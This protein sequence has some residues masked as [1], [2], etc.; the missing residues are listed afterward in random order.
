MKW[1]TS[2]IGC[3][4]CHSSLW[5]T[6]QHTCTSR[7]VRRGGGG[8]GGWGVNSPFG[9]FMYVNRPNE[10]LTPPPFLIKKKK[11]IYIYIYISHGRPK[12][13]DLTPPPPTEQNV[14]FP[15][16]ETPPPKK[17]SVLLPPPPPPPPAYS[18][19]GW[20]VA[21]FSDRF[22]NVKPPPPPWKIPAY[23]PVHQTSAHPQQIPNYP[24]SSL[25][26]PT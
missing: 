3:G 17:K 9:N 15:N 23:A 22:I 16:F 13:G 18:A 8:G 14:K 2:W 11:Y 6:H 20:V 25:K 26:L 1:F 19:A 24:L 5:S 21:K 7:R 4:V 12:K 10:N